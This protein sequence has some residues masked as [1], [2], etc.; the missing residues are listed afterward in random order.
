MNKLHVLIKST[1]V[2]GAEI[3]KELSAFNINAV[4]RPD[5]SGRIPSEVNAVVVDETN[6]EA[7]NVYS[8]GVGTNPEIFVIRS[9]Q[10]PLIFAENGVLYLSADLGAESIS[11]LIRHCI[12]GNL[13]L[14]KLVTTFLMKTGIPTNKV[15]YQSLVEAIVMAIENPD[16]Y[17]NFGEV[18][19]PEIARKTGKSTTSVERGIRLLLKSTYNNRPDNFFSNLFGYPINDKPTNTEFIIFCAEKIRTKWL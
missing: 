2:K 12:G 17:G 16:C 13:Q 3:A 18:I 4:T 7:T 5:F 1:S 9:G 11:N 14:K 6:G 8:I 10:N 15:G 19:Y